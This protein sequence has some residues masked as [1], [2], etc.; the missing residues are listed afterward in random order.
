[1]ARRRFIQSREP[2]YD[3][4]EVSDDYAPEPRNTD[5]A[6]WNDRHYDGL[7]ATDGTDISSR[8]KHRRYMRLNNVTTIDDFKGSWNKAQQQR[9]EYRTGKRGTVTKEDIGRAIHELENKRK[10]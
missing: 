6:L 5:S 1:M 8:T 7:R 3:F 9:D 4:T 2:P 10:A